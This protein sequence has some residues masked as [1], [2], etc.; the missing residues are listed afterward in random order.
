MLDLQGDM[1]ASLDQANMAIAR[2]DD[3]RVVESRSQFVIVLVHVIRH[4]RLT[5]IVQ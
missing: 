4:A 5:R 1:S 3:A 2:V